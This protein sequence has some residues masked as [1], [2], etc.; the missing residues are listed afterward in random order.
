MRNRR[1]LHLHP[2]SEL[3]RIAL[4]HGAEVIMLTDSGRADVSSIFEL[5]ILGVMVG[6]IMELSA[7]GESA[8]DA[9][10]A[11]CGFLEAH[12]DTDSICSLSGG[13]E[14]TSRAA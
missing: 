10:E 7:Y 14:I 8:A 2:A 3:S 13:D 9:L 4:T 6:D 11:V 12:N 1:G 5:L